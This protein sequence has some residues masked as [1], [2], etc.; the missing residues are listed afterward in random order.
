M[1]DTTEREGWM[2]MER[3]EKSG[4]INRYTEIQTTLQ[5]IDSA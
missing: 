5:T 2:C 1:I 3:E 4:S